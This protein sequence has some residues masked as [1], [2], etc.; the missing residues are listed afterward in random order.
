MI[1]LHDNAK[2]AKARTERQKK[3]EK[4]R[5]KKAAE[6]KHKKELNDK[7][8]KITVRMAELQKD[9]MIYLNS[10]TFHLNRDALSDT[11][12]KKLE[13]CKQK[14]H[15]YDKLRAQI[16][17]EPVVAKAEATYQKYMQQVIAEEK[18]RQ[19]E[20]KIAKLRDQGYDEN[21][22]PLRPEDCVTNPLEM[23]NLNKPDMS[24]AYSILPDRY[25]G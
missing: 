23:E 22:R 7:Y 21:M 2:Q 19:R 9:V 3:Q 13:K 17:E 18:K 1:K 20:E 15:E 12:L 24:L 11:E 10:L 14:A 6:R 25:T 4:Q 5:E 8:L 16:G